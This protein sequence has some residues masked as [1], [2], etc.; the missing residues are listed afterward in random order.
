MSEDNCSLQCQGG[1]TNNLYK[2]LEP[3]YALCGRDLEL[4]LKDCN[5]PGGRMKSTFLQGNFRL[6]TLVIDDCNLGEIQEGAFQQISVTNLK[7]LQML[8]SQLSVIE[9]S[10]FE[11]LKSL[12]IFNMTNS[13]YG[14]TFY[15]KDCFKP[16]TNNLQT[17]QILQQSQTPQSIDLNIWFHGNNF[18]NLKIVDLRDNNFRNVFTNE[19][20]A[21]LGRVQTLN[22]SNCNLTHLPVNIFDAMIPTLH[23]L[24]LSKNYLTTLDSE[25]LMKFGGLQS[26]AIG[27]NIWDCNCSNWPSL[28]ELKENLFSIV[29]DKMESQCFTPL[30]LRGENLFDMELDCSD[31]ESTTFS[32]TIVIETSRTTQTDEVETTGITVT[33]PSY[34]TTTESSGNTTYPEIETTINT[35]IYS[36]TGTEETTDE[37]T[38]TTTATSSSTSR[39]TTETEETSTT[40]TTSLSTSNSSTETEGITDEETSTTTATSSSISHSTTETTESSTSAPTVETTNTIFT[41]TTTTATTTATATTTSTSTSTPSLPIYTNICCIDSS[42]QKPLVIALITSNVQF[43]ISRHTTTSVWIDVPSEAINFNL[44]YFNNYSQAIELIQSSWQAI[45]QR[46]RSGYNLHVGDLQEG[47]V[48]LFCLIAKGNKE[49]SPFD[50]KSY[51]V[52]PTVPEPWVSDD[53]QKWIIALVVLAICLCI[54]MGIIGVFIVL[55]WRRRRAAKENVQKLSNPHRISGSHNNRVSEIPLTNKRPQRNNE[56]RSVDSR[57]YIRPQTSDRPYSMDLY[58]EMNYKVK[59]IFEI[60]ESDAYLGS[61]IILHDGIDSR[62]EHSRKLWSG[63]DEDVLSSSEEEVIISL[64]VSVFSVLELRIIG[65]WAMTFVQSDK[66]KKKVSGE[67]KNLENNKTLQFWQKEHYVQ[68]CAWILLTIGLCILIVTFYLAL[69][70]KQSNNDSRNYNVEHE[71][72]VD[73]DNADLTVIGVYAPSKDGELEGNASNDFH[74]DGWLD[75]PQNSRLIIENIFGGISRNLMGCQEKLCKIACSHD[76]HVFT[77]LFAI[78][79]ITSCPSIDVLLLDDQDFPN[80]TLDN[81]WLPVNISVHEIV[82][83]ASNLS[84]IKSKAFDTPIYHNTLLMSLLSLKIE[85]LENDALVG[86]NNLKYLTIDSHVD[87]LESGFFRPVQKTLTHLKLNA[88]LQVMGNRNLFGMS[89]MDKL[90]YLDLSSNN[91]SGP[92]DRWMFSSTPNLKYLIMVDCKLRHIESNTFQHL[93][94]KLIFL[95]LSKNKLI[96]L[97]A[98]IIE[99][100]LRNNVGAMISLSRNNWLC[101]CEMQKLSLIY[102]KYRNK[103]MDAVYCSSPHSVYGRSID[104][105]DYQLLAGCEV[106]TTTTVTAQGPIEEKEDYPVT[107]TTSTS[108]TRL[109]FNTAPPI[110]LDDL[111]SMEVPSSEESFKMRCVNV[112]SDGE[113][114]SSSSSSLPDSSSRSSETMER[115]LDLQSDSD[116]FKLPPP[117]HEFDLQLI[118]EN[119]TVIV[120]VDNPENLVVMWFSEQHEAD[121][122]SC[123]NRTVDYE[124]MRYARPQLMVGPLVENTTYTFCLVPPLQNAISP[125]NCLPLHVPL[126]REDNVWISQD[127]KQ[128]TIGMLCLIFLVSTIMGAL[129]AYFGI[130]TYPDL[131]EGSK[132]VLVVKKLDPSCYVAT[133]SETEYIKQASLKK[134]KPSAS[135]ECKKESLMKQ[136][137]VKLPLPP[138]PCDNHVEETPPPS[139]QMS[140]QNLE[141]LSSAFNFDCPFSDGALWK[142]EN[143]ETP[144][145]CENEYSLEQR[146]VPNNYGMSPRSPPPLPKRNSNLS[147]SPTVVMNRFSKNM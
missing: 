126:K 55:R 100:I 72:S 67:N 27:N 120:V 43:T 82:I 86:L 132:N 107:T 21:T 105:V 52:Y 45:H 127:Y 14:S 19:T 88:H 66:D 76:S 119:N 20:F 4:I 130:K 47:L 123:N 134:R 62:A 64:V 101:D 99:P 129:V 110:D 73:D 12:E 50:C 10:T 103:F 36:T 85:K 75:S 25:L 5:F 83:S 78:M 70:Q 22:L 91:I 1:N 90:E 121:F 61:G 140:V 92:M 147:D 135:N 118:A 146:S 114:K 84:I 17:L 18:T 63:I 2:D 57:D 111:D 117:S 28:K 71:G 124:C 54:F 9:K 13:I 41:S 106:L 104:E 128:F 35:S 26:L 108:T 16:F 15:E 49:V 33:T 74:M 133:I 102:Q 93:V 37:E 97:D 3:L 145:S 42:N 116:Y 60:S 56:L 48:Y 59:I 139:F 51:Y 141:R 6:E 39:S 44:V 96:T 98:D 87:K 65:P 81:S 53:D 58:E 112:D 122:V 69:H 144:R 95:N 30:D 94:D 24:D 7:I 142:E 68:A 89:F 46:S 131:L 138:V 31:G 113:S 79:M 125:F 38:S 40:T 143:Y 23:Y 77:S 109:Y 34:L 8:N 80:N 115:N 137:S 11:G 29:F 136:T 32:T